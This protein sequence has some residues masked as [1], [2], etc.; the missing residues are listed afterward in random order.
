MLHDE[1]D[2]L[3]SSFFNVPRINTT[4]TTHTASSLFDSTSHSHHS[5]LTTSFYTSSPQYEEDP[6][7]TLGGNNG[8]ASRFETMS[9]STLSPTIMTTPM[10]AAA[11]HNND[12][13]STSGTENRTAAT[14]DRM[15]ISVTNV[16]CTY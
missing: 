16:L 1:D 13:F 4:T 3:S 6:W 5:P 14:T 7:S 11:D 10:I 2:P 15:V 8:V 9:S 12:T